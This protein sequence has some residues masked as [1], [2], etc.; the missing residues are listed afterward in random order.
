MENQEWRMA[1]VP[2]QRATIASEHFRVS[3][4]TTLEKHEVGD[5]LR[6]LE[7]AHNDLAKRL[8]AA[9]INLTQTQLTQ[10]TLHSSTHEFVTVTGQPAWVAGATRGNTIH[11]QP[12][13][14][15][16]K[17]GIV[18]TT[19]RHEFAHAVLERLGN[20]RASRWLLEGLAIHFA[21]EGRLYASSKDKVE[22]ET[23]EK[24][25]SAPAAPAEMRVLYAAAYREVQALIRATGE[26]KVWQKATKP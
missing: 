15:L 19:L 2:I 17:R 4:P 9:S 5:V 14:A 13:L 12:L 18:A 6:V 21:G 8:N 10:V 23:L 3:Y 7:A 11:L 24:K 1:N 26:A 25:L 20:H 22:I 16:R